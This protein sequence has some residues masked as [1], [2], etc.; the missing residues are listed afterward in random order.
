MI[1]ALCI[2][3]HPDDVEIAM[4]A[5]VAGMARRG[6]SVAIVDLTDGEPTPKAK[7]YRARVSY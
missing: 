7:S 1:D 5:T 2:G 6:L 4:G 3:T